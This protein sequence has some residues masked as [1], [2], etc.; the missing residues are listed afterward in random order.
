MACADAQLRA[1]FRTTAQYFAPSMP[2]GRLLFCSHSMFN[3]LSWCA[4]QCVYTH[5]HFGSISRSLLVHI[6]HIPC[7]GAHIGFVA[8]HHCP[9]ALCVCPF[10]C[11]W[12]G[13]PACLTD[14][15]RTACWGMRAAI[16]IG[17]AFVATLIIFVACKAYGGQGRRWQPS[18]GGEARG[19]DGQATGEVELP[20][21]IP[22]FA[23]ACL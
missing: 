10:R 21:C 3:C 19:A 8:R 20:A 12:A 4:L 2:Q 23:R 17:S 18:S 22:W 1:Y 6:L 9:L 5:I 7:W 11:R 15:T 16:A 13:S 14:M